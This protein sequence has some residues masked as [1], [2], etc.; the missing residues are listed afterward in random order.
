MKG[1]LGIPKAAFFVCGPAT[2]HR[3]SGRSS[4]APGNGPSLHLVVSHPPGPGG[5]PHKR[6][7]S[8]YFKRDKSSCQTHYF[9]A[10][11]RY[12]EGSVCASGSWR[13]KQRTRLLTEKRGCNSLRAHP[14]QL[15]LRRNHNPHPLRSSR[16]TLL[17]DNQRQFIEATRAWRRGLTR[18]SCWRRPLRTCGLHTSSSVAQWWS[19]RLLTDPTRVRF[20]PLEPNSAALG[21]GHPAIL[22]FGLRAVLTYRGTFRSVLDRSTPSGITKRVLV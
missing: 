3:P 20:S 7:T 5:S 11:W 19:N 4:P 13:N 16:S 12:R 1:R 8:A 14:V 2:T 21:A 6:S 10:A 9:R 18:S 17:P 15:H 22:R